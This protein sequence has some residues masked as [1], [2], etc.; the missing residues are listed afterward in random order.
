MVLTLFNANILTN[1]KYISTYT[2]DSPFII[3]ST[4]LNSNLNVQYLN[5]QDSTYYRNVENMN[6]GVLPTYRGGTGS[7]Y[8]T[9]SKL[10]VGGGASNAILSPTDLHWSFETSRF[11]I[12][13]T[14]P[15][16]RLH[17]DGNLLLQ[18]SNHQQ[19]TQRT[20]GTQNT[21]SHILQT[22]E[23]KAYLSLDTHLKLW[24]FSNS[25]EMLIWNQ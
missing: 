13:L 1:Q 16:E 7:N 18:S 23:S 6:E 21:V 22:E 15:Q 20:F 5:Y 12:G 2:D 17:I 25:S 19:F 10:L 8:Q 4:Y 14:A 3:Q 24:S 9:L 11:G